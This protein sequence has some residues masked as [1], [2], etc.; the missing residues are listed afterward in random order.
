MN[1]HAACLAIDHFIKAE[2]FGGAARLSAWVMQQEMTENEL[3]NLLVL[4]SCTKWAELPSE[5]QVMPAET[6]E[7]EDV[8]DDDVVGYMSWY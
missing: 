5:K 8:S 1:E 4:Y 2:D 6:T 3:L 7:E